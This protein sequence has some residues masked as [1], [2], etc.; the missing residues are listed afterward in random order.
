MNT[1]HT[2]STESVT[3]AAFHSR[4]TPALH[5]FTSCWTYTS[6]AGGGGRE[7]KQ[8][9]CVEGE[10]K[11]LWLDVRVSAPRLWVVTGREGRG[12][13]STSLCAVIGRAAPEQQLGAQAF[14]LRSPGGQQPL[15]LRDFCLWTNTE[16]LE[17]KC[18]RPVPGGSRLATLASSRN[19][20]HSSVCRNFGSDVNIYIC[21]WLCGFHQPQQVEGYR[22]VLPG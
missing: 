19:R 5:L 11:T 20:F 15:Q 9:K 21:V 4:S 2:T 16:V 7:P 18:G 14:H 22:F 17:R 6:S 1:L 3:E 8:A 10:R 13:A 12:P